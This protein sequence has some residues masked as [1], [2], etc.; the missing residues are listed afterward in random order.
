MKWRYFTIISVIIIS[1]IFLV[2]NIYNLQF[3]KRAFYSAQAQYQNNAGGILESERGNI[4]FTDKNN[5]LIPAVLNKDYFVIFS[6][7]KEIQDE[8]NK[9]DE[10][11]KE[12]Q[13]KEMSKKISL[14]LN[15]SI[16]DL[17]KKLNKKNDLYEL[18]AQKATNEQVEQINRLDI[19]GVYVKKQKL[20]FYPF[21]NLASH[22]MGFVS[23]PNDKEI[24]KY[25][26]TQIGRYGLELEFNDLLTGQAGSFNNS[27]I[28][29]PEN[30][31]NLMLTLDRNIQAQSEEIL[32]NLIDKW[33]ASG[34]SI[35][36]Q[37]PKSGKILSM[38]NFP[39]FDPNNYSEFEIKNFLNPAVQSVYEPGSV[40]KLI[41]MATGIDSGKITPET[42]YVDSGSITLN[43][44]T[45]KNWDLKAYGKQTMSNVIEHS[46]NTGSVFAERKIGNDIFYNY[47]NKFGF[48]ELTDIDLPGEVRGNINNLKNG[49]EIDFATA[50][51]GQ[52]VAVTPIRLI[53][54]ISAIA[55][56]G[57]LMKPLILADD[58]PEVA[59]RV[60]SEDTANK[61]ADMMVSAVK[62]NFI[63]DI[64]NYNIA[65][66][67][68]TAFIP[69]FKKGGY[70]TSQ[71]IHTYVGFAPANDPKFA[72]LIKLEKPSAPLAGQTVVPAF[73]ELAQFILNYYN[74]APDDIDVNKNN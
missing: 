55:N 71:V 41:T 40:F 54:A 34:G 29:K 57:I 68:G 74:A 11:L 63:A 45:I 36:V 27:R 42:T 4:Y 33:S 72:I 60:V 21:G 13:F 46:I 59:R 67:T 8:I 10:N 25:G 19:K 20:R 47:L 16:E 24:S 3:N 38:A 64:P 44:K 15:I 14:I 39:D 23:Q 48:N 1:H 52:G 5:N 31:K 53:N 22:L 51:F 58:K 17:E 65:G 43:G 73:R 56:D 32:K 9:L 30:G 49:K 2:F 6:V 12:T 50:S 62:K 26:N 37:E 69:D 28:I 70:D 7:P 66:K 61:V 18:L 35:I